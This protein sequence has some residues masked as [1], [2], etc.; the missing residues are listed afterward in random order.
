MQAKCLRLMGKKLLVAL[1]ME[2]KFAGEGLQSLDEDDDMLTSMAKE[3]VQKNGIGE[4]ADSVWRQLNAEHQRLFPAR[5]ETESTAGMPVST[6][7]E[8]SV[9]SQGLI[10]RALDSHSVLV[11]GQQPE[12]LRGGRRRQRSPEPVQGLL[13]HWN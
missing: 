5:Q 2:G 6:D 13:F 1:A 10:D 12:E 4:T 7:P 11:F 8:R 3:L 9:S